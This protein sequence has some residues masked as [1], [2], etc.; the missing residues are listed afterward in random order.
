VARSG[1]VSSDDACALQEDGEYL[2]M[3]K[4]GAEYEKA[5]LEGAGDVLTSALTNAMFGVL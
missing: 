5:V 4:R 2:V 1:T 3:E